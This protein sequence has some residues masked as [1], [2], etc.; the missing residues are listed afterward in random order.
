MSNP[1]TRPKRVAIVHDWLTAPGGAERVLRQMLISYPQADL[2]S[3]VDFLA[4]KHRHL[5]EGRT[6][7][8]SFIQRLPFANKKHWMY[9]PL[10]PIA[11]EQFDLSGYDLIL[12][13]SY[14]VAKGVLTGPEQVHLSYVHT[15]IRYAWHL[16]HQYLTEM[17][18]TTGLKS[19][20]V[21]AVL[22]YMRIW[23]LRSAVNVDKILANSRYVG[24]QISRMYR[25]E[26]AVLPPP[27]EVDRFVL[28]TVKENYYVTA[29][30]MVPYK[31]IDLIVESFARMPDR[32]LVVV[33]DG[34][35]MKRVLAAAQGHSNIVILGY[36]SDD[37]LKR[38]VSKAKAFVF[39]AIED[40]GISPVEAQAAGTPV[41]CL[42][43]GGSLET[44]QP[45][46]SEDPTGV[47]FY[48]QTHEDIIEA[49]DQF[50]LHAHRIKPASCRRNAERFASERFRT[51]LKYLVDEA[52][53][54]RREPRERTSVH[55][56]HALPP[57]LVKSEAE[58]VA[59]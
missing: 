44:I 27:V 49:V 6:P 51:G 30:R 29:S 32:K 20:C 2:Y 12:S 43:R 38:L 7:K 25:Q 22:H 11:V 41:I 14:C 13:S 19:I 8:T 56:L 59:G 55:V 15:P 47:Y 37:E 52:L 48:D 23:D 9:L 35:D 42:G 16:Q 3:I 45:L 5:L 31:R 21:R 54:N 18:L 39:A 10:M 58:R 17:H 57:I 24:H 34:P 53:S 28:E 40:F 1:V 26:F 46:D 33:G 50:E 4:P 36:Q